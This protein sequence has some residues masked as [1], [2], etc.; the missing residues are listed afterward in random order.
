[1]R[2]LIA[3]LGRQRVALRL[4][5]RMT[6]AGVIAFALGHLLGFEQVFWAVLTAIIVMQA[7][8]GGSLKATLDRFFGS[9]GG[10][11]W[12]VGVA[13]VVPHHTLVWLGVA[14][15]IAVALPA[16]VAALRPSYR[17]APITA[18][19][20]L[21][22]PLASRLEL[23]KSAID[24]M[25]EIGLGSLIALV[26]AI[27]VLPA[28]AHGLL[29]ATA[30]RTLEL[31]V[32]L[33]AMLFSGLSTPVD[34]EAVQVLH[35]RI[36]LA[37][38]RCDAA[39]DEALRERTHYLSDAPHPG[40]L[41][42]TLRR[43]RNDLVMIGRLSGE[44]LPEPVA[45]RLA[46]SIGR[47]AEEFVGFLRGS[48]RALEARTASPSLDGMAAARAEFDATLAELRRENVL[49]ALPDEALPRLFGL[50]FALEQLIH[51]L[52]DL[53]ARVRELAR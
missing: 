1:M 5:F 16:L 3:W 18:A 43:V 42:R 31:M 26:V 15:A 32:D 46:P 10:A 20:V 40:P 14:L 38:S 34:Q 45:Q 24:R 33:A 28:R 51:N 52:E 8:L 23:V 37:L 19:I 21:L 2:S 22:S 7:S 29:A 17:V 39:A 47:V 13:L 6:I 4:S 53:A 9:L 36:R 27:V 50:Q 44:P 11:A 25:L 41:A 48:A 49:R 30:A 35:D 12:G